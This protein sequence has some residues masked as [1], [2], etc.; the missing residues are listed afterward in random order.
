MISVINLRGL[1]IFTKLFLGESGN[2]KG[3]QSKKFGF[4]F[5]APASLGAPPQL[6]L[7][8]IGVTLQIVNVLFRIRSG[9]GRGAPC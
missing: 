8:M 9:R 4:A 5:F 2:S 3:L 7:N 1:Q 6:R